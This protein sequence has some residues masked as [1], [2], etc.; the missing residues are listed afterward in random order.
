MTPEL[1]INRKQK[2]NVHVI[3][4]AIMPIPTCTQSK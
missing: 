1:K 4:S 2:V 3:Y